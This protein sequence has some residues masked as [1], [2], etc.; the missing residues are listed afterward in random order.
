MDIGVSTAT[1]FL[2]RYNE[3]SISIIKGLG[4]QTC[5]VFL[6][7]PSEYTEEYGRLLNERKG[8]L[9]VHSIHAVTMNYETE[10]FNSFDR[11][12]N[13][14]LKSFAGVLSIGKILGA[15]FYTMHGRARI[16]KGG[17]YDDYV[18]NGKRLEELCDFARNYDIQICLENVAWALCNRPE[19]YSEIV[20]F[21]PSIGAT[22]DVKQA[23]ISGYDYIEYLT[24]MG[25]RIRTVHL[26]DVDSNGKIR[27]PGK[28]NFN[29]KE[30]FSRLKDVG[31]NGDMIVEV[32]K[33]DY[34]NEAEITQSLEFL[35]ELKYKIF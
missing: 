10:L 2:R 31:F 32:Y 5:E 26:S 18:K 27:L 22:L 15:H 29:F 24:A 9:K 25:E 30:L 7:C 13:D 16:K 33:D 20:K 8:D 3:D 1:F 4:G 14:A 28:G 23:R 6:E 19:F 34:G 21:A 11:A 12:Y 35:N 17:N